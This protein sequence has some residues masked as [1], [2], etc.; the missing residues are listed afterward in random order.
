MPA[1][2]IYVRD[3]DSE[4]WRKAE[5]YAQ[6]QGSSFSEVLSEAVSGHL[7]RLSA[8]QDDGN[9]E[10]DAHHGEKMI[11]LNVRLFTNNIAKG[12]DKIVPK[13]AWAA[14]VVTIRPNEAHGIKPIK[15]EPFH[16]LLD[17]PLAIEKLLVRA[18]IVLH[19][20][21]RMRRYLR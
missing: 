8:A 10:A 12:T 6:Q 1:K 19:V 18:G 14:G 2:T 3:A 17:L 15:P 4:T 7:D 20:G 13:H 9:G 5:A 16:T 11:V 21:Q